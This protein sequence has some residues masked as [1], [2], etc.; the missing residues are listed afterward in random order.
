MINSPTL[1]PL[2]IT[3]SRHQVI[4]SLSISGE[5]RPTSH[6]STFSKCK[7]W[8]VSESM[9]EYVQ[10]LADLPGESH[11]PSPDKINSFSL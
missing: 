2:D 7:I 6:L 1:I 3:K 9:I 4:P 10:Y 8:F 11:L 5:H